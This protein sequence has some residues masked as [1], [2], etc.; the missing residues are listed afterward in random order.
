LLDDCV[1]ERVVLQRPFQIRKSGCFAD[2]EKPL[3][4]VIR[5]NLVQS[6]KRTGFGANGED[7]L[8]LGS[9]AEVLCE[10]EWACSRPT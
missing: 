2:G 7:F 10:A 6:A 3:V 1:L 8:K 4:R 5:K 9:G